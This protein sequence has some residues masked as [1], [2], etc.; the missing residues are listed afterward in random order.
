MAKIIFILKN[1]NENAF[2]D[3]STLIHL[4]IACLYGKSE[5]LP[6]KFLQFNCLPLEGSILKDLC[7]YNNMVYATG[8]GEGC[9]S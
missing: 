9:N 6:L 3:S 5:D 2:N 7:I 4:P 1:G 8:Q